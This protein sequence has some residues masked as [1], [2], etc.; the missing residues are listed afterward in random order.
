MSPSKKRTGRGL[1]ALFGDEKPKDLLQLINLTL[2][3]LTI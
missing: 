2:F 1:S 3:Q